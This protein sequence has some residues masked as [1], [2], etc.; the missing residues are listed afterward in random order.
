MC[1]ASFC[2]CPLG[3]TI[4]YNTTPKY[5]MTL[6]NMWFQISEKN[7][8]QSK[9]RRFTYLIMQVFVHE[10]CSIRLKTNVV[11]AAIFV[12]LNRPKISTNIVGFKINLICNRV[13]ENTIKKPV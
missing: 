2:T 7:N 3:L 9:R 1:T 5:Y 10:I 8:L 4:S 6:Y 11:T 12:Q 13:F